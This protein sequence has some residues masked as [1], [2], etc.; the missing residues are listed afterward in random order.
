MY[1]TLKQEIANANF[2]QIRQF[3]TS[4]QARA[5]APQQQ[6]SGA[7]AVCSPDTVAAFTAAGYFFGRELHQVLQVPIGL[8]NSSWGGTCVEAWTPREAL[9]KVEPGRAAIEQYQRSESTYDATKAQQQF[10][11]AMKRYEEAVA[12]YRSTQGR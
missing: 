4:P 12:K 2:P 8:I 6:C 10:S 11:Q 5:D 9:A 3:K 7:W 1:R